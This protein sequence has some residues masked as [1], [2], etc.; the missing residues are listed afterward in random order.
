MSIKEVRARIAD[1]ELQAGKAMQRM[2]DN[3]DPEWGED[4]FAKLEYVEAMEEIIDLRGILR[5]HE[6]QAKG[7]A[8]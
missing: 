4:C 2:V 1:L 7:G 8:A 6:Y 5:A 3:Y